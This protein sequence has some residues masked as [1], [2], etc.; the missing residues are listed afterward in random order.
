LETL[1]SAKVKAGAM[2]RIARSFVLIVATSSA[3]VSVSAPTRAASPA[4]A[5]MMTS[6][7]PLAA[8]V[9]LST[10]RVSTATGTAGGDLVTVNL[11]E[12]G[13]SVGLLHPAS[14]AAREQVSAMTADAH[15]VAGINADFFNIDESQHPG[16]AATGSSDG[17]EI[18]AGQPL[19]AAVP[20]AQRFGPGLAPGT[21]TRDVVGL[22]TDGRARLDSLH[23]EG[24]AISPRGRFALAGFNQYALAQNGIEA[25][26][27]AWGTVSRERAVCGSD[28]LRADPCVA[29]AA[30]VTVSQGRVV[31]V[32]ANPGEGAIAPGSTVLVGRESGA[33]KLRTFHVG[34]PIS[35]V[36]QLAGSG[37]VPFRFAVGGAPILRAGETLPGVNATTAA[38]RTAA[39]VSADG[40]R[41]YLVVLDGVSETSSGMTLAQLADLL[42]GF[43]ASDGVNFDGGGSSTCAVRLP[44]S[45][46]VTVVNDH[47][48]GVAE[49]AVAN[50]IGVFSS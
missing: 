41:L 20:D 7:R 33:D 16:V 17:P 10:F 19:K 11:A 45:T 21:S 26:T 47:P 14:V 25:F 28:V 32:S 24:T 15:A 46:E 35:V 37:P 48:N 22:G 49:R 3:L 18:S 13:V 8:G 9:D 39:G 4:G 12:P 5:A 31:A 43:G 1:P 42:A 23:L 34:D 6:T 44:G 27:S 36:Y 50:G 38:T 30:E 40:Q 2:P 29:D